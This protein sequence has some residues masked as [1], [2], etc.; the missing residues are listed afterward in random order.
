MA[1]LALKAKVKKG[2][3]ID[4]LRLALHK[5][6]YSELPLWSAESGEN[7]GNNIFIILGIEAKHR[8]YI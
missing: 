5:A 8:I 7:I 1:L 6:R 4:L 2:E 3:M